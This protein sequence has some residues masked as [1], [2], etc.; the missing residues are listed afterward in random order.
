MEFLH[1]MQ[2]P[3]QTLLGVTLA[4]LGTMLL[5]NTSAAIALLL[6]LLCS[7]LVLVGVLRFIE[8]LQSTRWRPVHLT[9][10]MLLV[11][12]GVVLLLWRTAS[13]PV[14]ALSVSLVLLVSGIARLLSTVG[15]PR[16]S[17]W[18]GLLSALTG[19]FASVLVLF[20]PRLSLWVVAVAFRRLAD[21]TRTTYAVSCVG[22]ST[23]SRAAVASE[24]DSVWSRRTHRDGITAHAGPGRGDRTTLCLQP[25]YGPGRV[26][27]ASSIRSRA[28]RATRAGRAARTWSPSSRP[29]LANPLSDHRSHRRTKPIL[30]RSHSSSAGR[31]EPTSGFLGQ[32]NQGGPTTLRLIAG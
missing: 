26:L 10:A 23:S 7:G 27:S 2:R 17:R 9:A 15:Q 4:R 12:S 32:R 24:I 11:V 14:L 25:P 22:R 8:A 6:A 19:L 28:T 3:G 30:G 5:A 29:G 21:I 31:H 18:R 13:L 16:G 20:W 1:R